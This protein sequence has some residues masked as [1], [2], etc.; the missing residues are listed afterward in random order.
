M[1]T[2]E[3]LQIEVG[4]WS[5]RN[6]PNNKLHHP[7]LGL[8]EE[9][10]ELRAADT[11]TLI[12]DAIGDA[13]IYLGDSCSRNGATLARGEDDT[14]EVSEVAVG[15]LCHA[16]LKGEQGIRYAREEIPQKRQAAVHGVV[17]VLS[18]MAQAQATTL[19][20]IASKTWQKVK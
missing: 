5:R 3:Q 8:V 7:L 10:G 1:I 19:E 6:F 11:D 15:K 18:A 14:I 9:F 13:S 17:V 4:E 16:H 12:I 20:D 2:L